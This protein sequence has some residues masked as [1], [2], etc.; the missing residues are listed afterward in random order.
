MADELDTDSGCLL[1]DQ[2]TPMI[3]YHRFYYYSLP[4]ELLFAVLVCIAR[5]QQLARQ[6]ETKQQ[7]ESVDVATRA[8]T[9]VSSKAQPEISELIDSSQ[10][11]TLIP[12]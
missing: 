9:S 4:N 5:P 3:A 1:R 11:S 8:Q 6:T 10:A 12:K 7:D 2:S